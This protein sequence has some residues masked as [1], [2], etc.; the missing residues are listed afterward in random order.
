MKSP[1]GRSNVESHSNTLSKWFA[2]VIGLLCF[3]AAEIAHGQIAGSKGY[4]LV[5]SFDN[6]S[7]FRYDAATGDFV[8]TFI[9]HKSGG[10][11]QPW[12]IVFGPYDGQVYVSSGTFTPPS[13]KK[14]VLRYDAVTGAYLDDFTESGHLDSPRGIIFGPDGHFF[15]ISSRNNSLGTLIDCDGNLQ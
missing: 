8:D 2:L 15:R 12:G 11:V 6:H 7:V 9:P 10:L 3:A 4:L 13:Q 5:T 1:A 14:G